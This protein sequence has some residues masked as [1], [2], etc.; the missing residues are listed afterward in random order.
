MAIPTRRLAEPGLASAASAAS[1]AV[2][3]SVAG[4]EAK[5]APA[6]L[7]AGVPRI[8]GGSAVTP[9]SYPWVT[10]LLRWGSPMCG[11]SY[12]S[13]NWILTA[14]H[15]CEGATMASLPAS[16]LPP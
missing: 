7:P 14:A 16:P 12:L 11:A 2:A 8:V 5:I 4:A 6:S 9:F 3:S 1:V 15:C 13:S 10:A